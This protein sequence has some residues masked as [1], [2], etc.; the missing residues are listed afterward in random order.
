MN[1]E[2]LFISDLHLT[3]DQPET[4]R[5]FLNFLQQ[6]A[7]GV[8][9]L[10]ILGDFFDTW[11]GD[12][13]LTPP[14]KTIKQ[15]LKKL[16]DSGTPVYLQQGNRDFLVG[17]QFCQ[18]TGVILL[19]DYVVIDLFDQATLLMHGDLLCSDD[20][21]YL[22]FRSKSRTKEWQQMMLSKPLFLRLLIGRWY[23]LRSHFHK[24]QKSQ[25]IKDVNQQ[26]VIDTLRQYQ[27]LRLIHG[28]THRPAIHDLDVDGKPAQ[29]FVLPDWKHSKPG[30]L[31]W[32]KQ[33]YKIE[34]IADCY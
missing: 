21:D 11:I 29:R 1:Q 34:N 32:Q 18:E 25:E 30:V 24:C 33:G 10:Y 27:V 17:S 28:H 26:T 15:A 20:T 6:R 14:H 3:L 9:A 8:N 4:T 12:D 22:A 5:L 31:C 19:A 13:D 2:I 7:T 23:R 16:I